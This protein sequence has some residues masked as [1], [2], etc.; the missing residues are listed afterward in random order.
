VSSLLD[1]YADRSAFPKWVGKLIDAGQADA[2]ARVRVDGDA[3]TIDA[4][5]A[6]NQRIDLDARM[7]MAKGQSTGALYARWGVLGLGAETS[8]GQHKLHL[9]K[10]RQ[11]YDGLPAMTAGKA[12]P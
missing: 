5:R 2:T 11:W 7:R 3:V 4:L 8:G 9:L 12:S 10:A 6:R 1:L